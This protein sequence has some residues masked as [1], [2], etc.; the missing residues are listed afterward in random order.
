MLLS[1][2]RVF[3]RQSP[4][5]S[6]YEVLAVLENT[7]RVQLKPG[8]DWLPGFLSLKDEDENK[9][10]P[11]Q[12]TGIDTGAGEVV[13]DNPIQIGFI[14]KDVIGEVTPNT[15]SNVIEPSELLIKH[16]SYYRCR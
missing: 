2:L 8:N 13:F 15:R 10:I 9:K 16:A 12:V 1:V 11:L 6:A 7:I 5:P 14:V 4:P 3:L